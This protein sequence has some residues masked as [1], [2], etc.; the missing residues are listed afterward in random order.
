VENEDVVSKT[1]GVRGR[2]NNE[3][4]KTRNAKTSQDFV[5]DLNNQ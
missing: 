5:V 4:L 2:K 1:L 3:Q